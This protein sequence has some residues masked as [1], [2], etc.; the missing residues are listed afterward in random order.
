MSENES[1]HYFVRRLLADPITDE[2]SPLPEVY[3]GRLPEG[4]PFE[5]PV[6]EEAMLLGGVSRP[7]SFGRDFEVLLESEA[8]PEDLAEAFRR[9]LTAAGWEEQPPLEPSGFVRRDAARSRTFCRSERGPAILVNIREVEDFGRGTSV[10]RVWLDLREGRNSPCATLR[11]SRPF[12]QGVLPRLEPPR[13]AVLLPG[14]LG[15]GGGI[16][17]YRSGVALRT[18]LDL[19]ELL[20]HY[21]SQLRTAEW[22]EIDRELGAKHALSHWAFSR[23]GE[24]WNAVFS[25]ASLPGE[26]EYMLNIYARRD[27]GG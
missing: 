9:L 14:G 21:G 13:R 3:P 20:E 8:A 25:A 18:E 6:P 27:S 16:G 17:D 22:S 12:E 10:V 7:A 26:R 24:A 5:I 2:T 15:G 19:S 4:L 11:S 23:D 1:I